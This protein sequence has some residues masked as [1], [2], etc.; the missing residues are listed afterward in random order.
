VDT[1]EVDALVEVVRVG[2]VQPHMVMRAVRAMRVAVG[3]DTVCPCSLNATSEQLE[4][5]RSA[6]RYRMC[7]DE[8]VG[9]PN[10]LV[11]DHQRLRKH[12]RPIGVQ[13]TLVAGLDALEAETLVLANQ[14]TALN[15]DAAA[16]T[17]DEPLSRSLTAR[18]HV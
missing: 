15:F 5:I 2:V 18:D 12:R 8:L 14:I 3:A 11:G 6:A 1:P 17:A 7:G 10:L 4:H 13:H 9:E 16:T